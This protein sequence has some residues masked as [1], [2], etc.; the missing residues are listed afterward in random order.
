MKQHTMPVLT[1]L[2]VLLHIG[3]NITYLKLNEGLDLFN[4][5]HRLQAGEK[6]L[7]QFL[8]EGVH[9]GYLQQSDLISGT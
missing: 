9:R 6:S 8:W 2:V 1:S 3:G 5:Q 4:H 7:N